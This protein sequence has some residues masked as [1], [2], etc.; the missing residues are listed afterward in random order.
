MMVIIVERQTSVALWDSGE[1]EEGEERW[2]LPDMECTVAVSTF[3]LSGGVSKN[4]RV[5]HLEGRNDLLDY[6]KKIKSV[7]GFECKLAEMGF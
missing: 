5:I 2:C 6:K 1:E 4:V 3:A 7:S